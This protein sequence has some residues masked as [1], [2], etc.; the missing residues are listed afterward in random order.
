MRIL[1]LTAKNANHFES[2]WRH[3]H[4]ILERECGDPPDWRRLPV[5]CGDRHVVT[6]EFGP[7][8]ERHEQCGVVDRYQLL[9]WWPEWSL[10]ALTNPESDH[11][12]VLEVIDIERQWV[13]V[14]DYQVVF[15]RRNADVITT[16]PLTDMT[17]DQILELLDGQSR[18]TIARG[19]R[20]APAV[21][22]S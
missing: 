12:V 8:M 6:G 5:P 4:F 18:H 1:R 22:Q 11:D 19:T 9:R 21:L 13:W 14:G 3:I 7:E 20:Y 15:S 2:N 16:I 17:T 10:N